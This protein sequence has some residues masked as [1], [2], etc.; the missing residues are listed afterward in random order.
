M[1]VKVVRATKQEQIDMHRS[2]CE[3]KAGFNMD[4]RQ[5]QNCVD[6]NEGVYTLYTNSGHEDF[7]PFRT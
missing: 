5:E 7:I 6:M 3:N 1:R 2:T 4:K